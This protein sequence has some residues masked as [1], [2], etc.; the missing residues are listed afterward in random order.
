MR[1]EGA[2]NSRLCYV[3]EKVGQGRQEY[4]DWKILESKLI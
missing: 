3:T 4:F 1:K 2:F